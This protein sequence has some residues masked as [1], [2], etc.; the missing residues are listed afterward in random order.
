[1]EVKAQELLNNDD[2]L[3]GITTADTADELMAVLKEHE[4]QLEEGLNPEHAFEMVQSS[5]TKELGDQ[6]LESVS[7]G[8]LFATA[9]MAAGALSF[10]C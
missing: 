9:A 3:K 5:K 2:L 8:I 4:I 6:E 10:N 1:M 7:G